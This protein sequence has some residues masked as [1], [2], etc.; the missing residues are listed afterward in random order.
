MEIQGTGVTFHIDPAGSKLVLG[1]VGDA[2]L[3]AFKVA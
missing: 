2:L 3:L 1:V